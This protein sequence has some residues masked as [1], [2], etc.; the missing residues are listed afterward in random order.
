MRN[1]GIILLG[2]FLVVS[3]ALAGPADEIRVFA[4]KQVGDSYVIEVP[5]ND[6]D[7]RRPAEVK[8]LAARVN[9]AIHQVCSAEVFTPALSEYGVRACMEK[10]SS[11]TETQLWHARK[12]AV[13]FARAGHSSLPELA[14]AVR[15]AY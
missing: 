4:L 12:R 9:R 1:F 6:L 15:V 10:A 8:V 7:L 3:P 2:G 14:I 11:V 5:Y 13:E